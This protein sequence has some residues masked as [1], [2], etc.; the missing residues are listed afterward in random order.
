MRVAALLDKSRRVRR[1]APPPWRS[2]RTTAPRPTRNCARLSPVPSLPGGASPPKARSLCDV[3]AADAGARQTCSVPAQCPRSRHWLVEH[4]PART[5]TQD[6]T[7]HDVRREPSWESSPALPGDDGRTLEGPVLSVR[8]QRAWGVAGGPVLGVGRLLLGRTVCLPSA[9]SSTPRGGAVKPC[10]AG[11]CARTY[12][13]GLTV[14]RPGAGSLPCQ[15]H[16]QPPIGASDATRRVAE[17]SEVAFGERGH[18]RRG[19]A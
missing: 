1:G 18:R 6:L 12:G 10:P 11:R 3:D 15:T 7:D 14:P 17:C 8:A 16:T 13:P 5:R 4:G 19:R 2:P 9:A